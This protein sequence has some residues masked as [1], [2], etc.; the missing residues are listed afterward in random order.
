MKFVTGEVVFRDLE[1]LPAWGAWIEID[2]G[3]DGDAL[4]ESLPAWGAWIEI[5]VMSV[6]LRTLGRSP[7]GE[8]GLK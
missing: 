5:E 3:D 1:S 7:H 6:V 2:L 8:R 4:R